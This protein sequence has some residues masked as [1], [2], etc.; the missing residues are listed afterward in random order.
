MTVKT[1]FA[2][3]CCMTPDERR[4]VYRA[5]EDDLRRRIASGELA[6]GAKLPSEKDIAEQWGTSR[7]TVRQA[8][9]ALY[10]DGLIDRQAPFGTF[11]RRRPGVEI[12]WTDTR[13]Q[14]RP[15]GPTS[16]FAR[17]AQQA[18]AVPDW[19]WTTRRERADERIAARLGIE[20]GDHVMTTGYQFL[21][22]G[23]PV[24]LSTSWEPYA[25]VGGT[26]IEE[27]EGGTGPVGVIARFDSI[28]I[29]IDTVTEIVRSR[30]ATGDERRTLNIAPGMWVLEIER[31]H[32]AGE[33]PVEICDIVQP[34]DRAARGY[35][36]KIL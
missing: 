19:R 32:L 13:Y 18:G 16:P 7:P 33:R 36:I 22:S 4:R 5:I 20:P 29:R 23:Q 3:V 21:V 2:T 28:G 10:A 14:R 26:P 8:L 27:P 1:V 34:A 35:R 6:E 17:D 31:T 11:V 25:I 15:D 9:G 30:P 24:Q 12:Q